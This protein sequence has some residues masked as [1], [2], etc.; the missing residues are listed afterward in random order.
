[1]T[2]QMMPSGSGATSIGG[3]AA[4]PD[5]A[6]GATSGR[7]ADVGDV[8]LGEL[9]SHV[10]SDLSTLMRQEIE[11]AKAEITTEVKKAGKGAGMLGGAGYAGHLTVL[12]ISFSAWWAL[13]AAI[14]HIGWAALIVAVIWGVIAA[15]LALNGRKQLRSVNPKPERTIETVR[16]VPG[17][18]KP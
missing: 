3:P 1:M 18:L 4:A 5:T 11:L 6:A 16:E 7:H 15:V 12:F 17:A 9:F 13:A 14:G 10:T 8:S 2:D